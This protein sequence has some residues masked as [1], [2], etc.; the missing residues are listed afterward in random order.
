MAYVKRQPTEWAALIDLWQSSG[1][2]LPAFCRIQGISRGTM[3]N[4]IYKPA[5][6]RAVEEARRQTQA[7]LTPTQQGRVVEPAPTA[8][9]AFLPVVLSQP[10]TPAPTSPEAG[11]QILLG[12]GRRIMLEVGFDATTLL[13]A[14]DVLEG[15]AC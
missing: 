1:L 14:I 15:R 10:I 8:G 12:E 7:A 9:P 4:W 5:L 13:R 6:R 2:S 11:I 3:Q